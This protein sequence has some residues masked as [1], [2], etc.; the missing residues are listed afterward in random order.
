MG[1]EQTPAPPVPPAVPQTPTPSSVQGEG[2]NSFF[3]G[4]I[5]GGFIASLNK[6]LLLGGVVGVLAGAYYQQE[7]GAPNVKENIDKVKALVLD[8]IDKSKKQ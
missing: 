5:A 2:F 8:S 3:K 1:K 4:L 6:R 7:F